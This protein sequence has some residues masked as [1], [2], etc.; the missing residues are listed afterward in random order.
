MT[1]F[2]IVKLADSNYDLANVINHNKDD[3][4]NNNVY[5]KVGNTVYESVPENIPPKTI[6]ISLIH[7]KRYSLCIY[8]DKK[9]IND[10]VYIEPYEI[11]INNKIKNLSIKIDLRTKHK[12]INIHEDL[13]KEHI[14]KNF[15]KHYFFN[16]QVL[17]T[18]FIIE[19]NE[20]IIIMDISIKPVRNNHF[21]GYLDDN[22][23][24][25]LLT[26]NIYINII[27]SNV[28]SRDLFKDDFDF[29]ELGIGGLN[30]QLKD[31]FKRALSTRAIKPEI[32]KKL[33]IKN[34]KGLL[35][36]GPPG[37]GKTLIARN[38]SHLLSNIEPKIVNGPEILNKYVG[39]SEKNIRD[40][41]ADAE[42]DQINNKQ[43]LHIIIFDEI[44]SICRSRGGHNST[45]SNIT[46]S[47]VTMLLSKMDGVNSLDN[48]FIIG[49][50]NRKE[51]L[52]PALLRAGRFELHVRIG[53][54]D[55]DG[56]KQIFMIH[57]NKM[58]ENSMIS[59]NIDFDML[60]N[61]TQ[62]F[63]G[64]EIEAIVKSAA[65]STLHKLLSN[66][67]KV[68]EESDIVVDMNDF[69]QA[70]SNFIPGFSN[71]IGTI[72]NILDKYE[73]KYK[74]IDREIIKKYIC[75]DLITLINNNNKN[76]L[77]IIIFGNPHS[78]KT[79]LLAKIAKESQI[80]C[81]KMILASD[82]LGKDE[83]QKDKILCDPFIGSHSVYE[84][85]NS[86]VIID[87]IEIILNYAE[88]GN[89]IVFSNKCYQSLM[90]I[91]KTKPSNSDHNLIIIA[92]CNNY[93]LFGQLNKFFDKSFEL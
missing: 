26:D 39:E 33:G 10:T 5:L 85:K 83:W 86:L 68:I 69:E 29:G 24:I 9:S 15:A 18:Q 53:L 75:K 28:L 61:L 78:G 36:Y 92:S 52:D 71:S 51:L 45:Q 11:N 21:E 17:I 62:N 13:F 41:F 60:A 58:R 84:S 57:T 50:T 91:L 67:D 32:I 37:T 64:A 27:S 7:R 20:N 3:F 48:I 87:D 16:K 25:K 23:E 19:D 46:D 63:S 89:S 56:R 49:M 55:Y 38:I 81:I 47:V 90:A 31:V 14:K 74:D 73:D 12:I 42:N 35:L 66:D 6:G 59:K 80:N 34:V 40:L 2:N 77:S 72:N 93:N 65:S 4:G 79:T 54:P 76:L 88:F 22:T 8:N 1:G 70:I 43:G 82:V 30:K 44:D